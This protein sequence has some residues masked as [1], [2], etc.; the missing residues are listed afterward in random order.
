MIVVNHVE[1][2]RAVW[3]LVLKLEDWERYPALYG[4]AGLRN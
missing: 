2:C 3:R 4:R 1:S